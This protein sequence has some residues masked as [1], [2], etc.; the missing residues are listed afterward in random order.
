MNAGIFHAL[1]HITC[2]EK[3]ILHLQSGKDESNP[4][5]KR[6]KI[7]MFYSLEMLLKYHPVQSSVVLK[8]SYYV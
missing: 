1:F 8:Y 6:L 4:T 7:T 5:I 3:H 2:S